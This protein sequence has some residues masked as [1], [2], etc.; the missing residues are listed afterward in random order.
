MTT[1]WN[2][3]IGV[4]REVAGTGGFLYRFNSGVEAVLEVASTDISQC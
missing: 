4:L 1:F 3:T 2:D